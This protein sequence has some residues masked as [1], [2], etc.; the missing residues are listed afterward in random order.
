MPA[1]EFEHRAVGEPEPGRTP[2]PPPV[3]F[4]LAV[5]ATAA[6]AAAGAL[7]TAL[8]VGGAID[9]TPLPGLPDAGPVTP[10]G[11]PAVRTAMN[12][13]AAVT[14]GLL[15]AAAF[16]V[17]GAAT[18]RRG[19]WLVSPA[20]YRW[21]RAAT[22]SAGV[23]VLATLATA[24]FTVSDLLGTTPS[25]AA[26]PETVLSFLLETDQGRALSLVAVGALA[27]AVGSRVVLGTGGAAAIAVLA[28]V[29]TLPPAFTGHA[30]GSANH[31]LAV[32]TMVLH[33]GAVV[34][35]VGGLVG[36]L[37]VRNLSG[38][39]LA[40]AV[41]RFSR[42]AGW[43]LLVVAGSG[44]VN[45]TARLGSWAALTGTPYGRLVL[46]KAAAVGVLAAI[47]LAH[48]RVTL[49]RVAAGRRSA[50]W[51]LA[52]VEIVVFAATVGLAA[53][54]SRSP[55]PPLAEV[56]PA[57]AL[58]G[59]PMPPPVSV[60]AIAT[61]WLV[62][63]LFLTACL[64]A[65]GAYLAGVWRLRRRGHTWPWYRTVCWLAGC[66]L[67][68]VVTSS[69]LARYGPVLF[70]VH[71]VQHMAMTMLA[72]VLLALGGPVTLALRALRPATEPGM[73]GPREWLVF[74]LHSRVARVATHP[75]VALA[76]YVASLYAMYFTG[77]YELALRSHAA[78]LAMFAHF[79]GAG[80]LFFW[81]L[82]GVDPAPRTVPYPLRVVLLFASMVFHAF[83]GVAIMQS[84]GLIAPDWYA[85]LA[86]PWGPST[87]DDQ[88]T[89]GGIAWAFG[90]IPS[91]LVAAA[92]L[93]SWARSDEREGRRLDRAAD[94]A[95]A[96]RAARAAD[97]GAD[98]PAVAGGNAP[99]EGVPE[100]DDDPLAAYNRYLR[101]LAERDRQRH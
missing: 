16:F 41:R 12:L 92:L 101:Q 63:P 75:L 11:L 94:R 50:F 78:H 98:G 51:R 24:V 17:P 69:G 48:R 85:E 73:R 25:T 8:V 36:L 35:W 100:D 86:R 93:Y 71:M 15:V 2:T 3:G 58:L 42:A 27:V 20:G 23:W 26:R 68:V 82:I 45:A 29:S 96:R 74:A 77:L 81:V 67:V 21:L 19:R 99:A 95:E 38:E 4:R 97:A 66:A 33:V 64:A 34:I 37:L 62:E 61:Q 44:L 43:C 31:Q 6:L 80:Y 7:V 59:F 10:W 87:L 13:A 57:T 56:G 9:T 54:L 79:L 60:S 72:P 22:W 46:A 52:G 47:G 91:L 88:H 49:P 39:G 5:L 40:L 83:F 89:G 14:V 70:S 65:A 28:L 18:P 90:E 32:S 53:G 76:L 84:T 1:R 55:T 30:A